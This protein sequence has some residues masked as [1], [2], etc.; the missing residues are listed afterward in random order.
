MKKLWFYKLKFDGV[1]NAGFF[2]VVV[3]VVTSVV[4]VSWDLLHK[5]ELE[6]GVRKNGDSTREKRRGEWEWEFLAVVA[7]KVAFGEE[8]VEFCF[9]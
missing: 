3:V 1:P 5:K 6:E 2:Q 4:C 8:A 9:V 7:G